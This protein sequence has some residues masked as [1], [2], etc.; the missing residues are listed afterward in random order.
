MS[1]LS[2]VSSPSSSSPSTQRIEIF[3]PSTSFDTMCADLGIPILG[4]IPLDTVVSQ[5]GDKGYPV[6]LGDVEK[7]EHQGEGVEV[8]SVFGK[9]AE[10]VWD[11][12][13]S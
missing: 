13:H 11:K 7:V 5:R 9:V 4:Q 10:G 12:L 6:V 3:G 1:H 8:R 2:L